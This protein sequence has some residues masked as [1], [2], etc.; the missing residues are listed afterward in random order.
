MKDIKQEVIYKIEHESGCPLC[1]LILDFEFQLLSKLQLDVSNDEN[2]RNRI[3]R[4]GGFCDFHFRQFKKITNGKTRIVFLK[5]IL[6]QESYKKEA[7]KIDCSLCKNI[8]NY[9]KEL[10]ENILRI[11]DD[12]QTLK[13]FEVSNG[14]CF[15]HLQKVESIIDNERLK[16]NLHA[17]N[18]K[19]LDRLKE[20]FDYMNKIDSYYEIDHSKRN[21]INALIQKLTGRKS[22]GL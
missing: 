3:A 20:D 17:I 22:G 11:L 19:Q 6:D 18:I 7:F 14:I 13:I 9:E 5:A 2:V 8:E 12:E 15:D 10:I 4:K 21:L 16:K 1:S